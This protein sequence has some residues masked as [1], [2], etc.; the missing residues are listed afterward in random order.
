MPD[1][2]VER[3]L[4]DIKGQIGKLEGVVEGRISAVEKQMGDSW[5][6]RR[7]I[8]D[9]LGQIKRSLNDI[10]LI[11]RDIEQL[12]SSIENDIK[13]GVDDYKKLKARGW[14][15][16]AGAGL[17]GGGAVMGIQKVLAKFGF[18]S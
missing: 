14:G 17:A 10:P 13:P 1:E 18:G 11:K 6:S 8:Y 3:L 12:Q 9:E 2:S 7:R 15:V 5:E 4:G 16:V